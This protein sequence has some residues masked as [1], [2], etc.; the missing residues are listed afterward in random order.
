VAD[1]VADELGDE[2][3]GDVVHLG[4]V[5]APENREGEAAGDAGGLGAGAER[6]LVEGGVAE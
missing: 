6:H 3:F 5:P 1:G 4:E 2:E